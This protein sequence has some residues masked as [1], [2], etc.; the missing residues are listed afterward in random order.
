[1]RVMPGFRTVS[2][3][4][5]LSLSQGY[6]FNPEYIIVGL[7]S[8]KLV[9]STEE[10]KTKISSLMISLSVRQHLVTMF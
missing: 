1:M 10:T 8:G 6:E 5:R 4:S 9:Q 7:L 3:I 2:G